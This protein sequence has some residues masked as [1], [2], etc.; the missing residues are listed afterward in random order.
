MY[1]CSLMIAYSGLVEEKGDIAWNDT[2]AGRR[3]AGRLH[4]SQRTKHTACRS[5]ITPAS[6]RSARSRSSS[7][8]FPSRFRAIF[9]RRPCRLGCCAAGASPRVLPETAVRVVAERVLLISALR[10][11]IALGVR[12]PNTGRDN[13]GLTCLQGPRPCLGG[14]VISCERRVAVSIGNSSPASEKKYVFCASATVEQ[15]HARTP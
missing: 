13:N 7:F 8:H 4:T 9:A 10:S 3:L 5:T 1:G 11:S 15:L 14:S 12:S 6:S 2:P